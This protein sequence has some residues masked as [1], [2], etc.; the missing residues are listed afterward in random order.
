VDQGVFA[1]SR[2]PL[3]FGTWLFFA[4]LI[5]LWAPL[6]LAVALAAL[7]F[8]ALRAM[9]LHEE[10]LLAG[11]L[12][13]PYVDYLARVP[14]WGWRISTSPSIAPAPLALAG[15]GRAVLPNLG[16]FSFGLFRVGVALGGPEKLLGLVNIACV[17]AWV[18]AVLV[19][20]A[21]GLSPA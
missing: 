9:V 2:N 21:R 1:R 4:A 14:R 15:L 12:G 6:A 8:A 16:L 5:L 10:Q 19:R 17:L 11:A 18:V 20:R 3:Y 13:S 7:F